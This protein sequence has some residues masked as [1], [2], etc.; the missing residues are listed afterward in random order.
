MYLAAFSILGPLQLLCSSQAAGHMVSAS[1]APGTP[2]KSLQP[3]ASWVSFLMAMQKE[4]S[5]MMAF[6]E[7]ALLCRAK[8]H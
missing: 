3:E 8:K 7:E 5:L 2:R 6:C 1:S 4:L